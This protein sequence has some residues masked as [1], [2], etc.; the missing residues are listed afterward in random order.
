M[1]GLEDFHQK[2]INLTFTTNLIFYKKSKFNFVFKYF[3]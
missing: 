2:F 3:F 1:N